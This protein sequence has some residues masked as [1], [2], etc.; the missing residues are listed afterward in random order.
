MSNIGIHVLVTEEQV[1]KLRSLAKATGL[2]VSDIIRR[3]LSGDALSPDNKRWKK[4]V[5][6]WRANDITAWDKA[7][8]K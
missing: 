7:L 5:A 8:S 3:L 6:A 1:D 4:I 2:P